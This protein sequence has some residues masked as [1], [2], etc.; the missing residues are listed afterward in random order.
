LASLHALATAHIDALVQGMLQEAAACDDVLDAASA[1]TYLED[2]LAF[3]GE[4]LTEE[5]KDKVRAGFQ[6]Y[7]SRW[8]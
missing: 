5:Q 7:T 2:R 8:D 1:L 6:S 3:F 4:L